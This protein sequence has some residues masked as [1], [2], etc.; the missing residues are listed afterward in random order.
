MLDNVKIWVKITVITT[1]SVILVAVALT[2]W[3]LRNMEE[4]VLMA[5]RQELQSYVRNVTNMIE[6][7]TRLGEAL[8]AMVANIPLVQEKFAAGDRDA[9]KTL[10]LSSYGVL[11]DNYGVRQFQFHTPPATS[12]L[13]LHKPKKYGDDLSSFRH[14]VTHTNETKKPTRGLESGV[15]GLGARGM[16]PVFNGGQHIGSVEFGMSFGP[17]FFEAFKKQY[18]VEIG[19]HLYKDKTFQT[20]ATTA[21]DRPLSSLDQ[22]EKA[23]NGAS[24]LHYADINGIS[25]A[26]IAEAVQDYSGKPIGVIEIAMDRSQ[27]QDTLTHSSTISLIFGFFV[28]ILGVVFSFFSAKRLVKRVDNVITTVNRIAEG[29]LTVNIDQSAITKDEVGQLQSAVYSYIVKMRDIITGVRDGTD[30]LANSTQQVND[31]AETLSQGAAAQATSLETT[32]S[33]IELL[34]ASIHENANNAKVTE[35]MATTAANEVKQ[36]GGAVDQTVTA[37]KQIAGK[38][39]LIE[40]IAYKTDLLSLNAAI[41]AARAGKHGKGFNVVAS[42]VRK[43]AEM[44]RLTA[45]EI[46]ELALNS[47]TVAENAGRLINEIVPKISETASLVQNITS[48]SQEQADSIRQ[49]NGAMAQLDKVIQQNADASEQLAVTSKE[50]NHEAGELQHAVAFYV[51]E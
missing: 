6:E 41:E 42:E 11:Y 4:L 19:L 9:L 50:L 49:I 16:V 29:D 23:Y 26:V 34:T 1:I 27:Y 47:V 39:N 28:L 22:L 35:K 10:L 30:R 48:A 24:Q 17:T 32:T 12:F 45:Q 44:S 14:T 25:H 8:S 43:L 3:N 2:L 46:N 31:T 21:G 5:E 7:E 51:C 36:G 18:G 20:F 13:R 33:A 40:D 37:M 38:V 15:A